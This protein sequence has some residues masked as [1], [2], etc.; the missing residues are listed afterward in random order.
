MLLDLWFHHTNTAPV[1][2]GQ[3]QIIRPD[4]VIK[5]QQTENDEAFLLACLL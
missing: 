4:E 2:I 5:P 1:Q 3:K